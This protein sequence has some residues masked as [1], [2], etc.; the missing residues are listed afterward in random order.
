M[1]LVGCALTFVQRTHYGR[2]V[3]T[4]GAFTRKENSIIGN[5]LLKISSFTAVCGGEGAYLIVRV[6]T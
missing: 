3:S 5:R 2:R 4:M 6:R 1:N